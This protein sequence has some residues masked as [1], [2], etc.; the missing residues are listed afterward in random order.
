MVLHGVIFLSPNTLNLETRVPRYL[1][2]SFHRNGNNFHVVCQTLGRRAKHRPLAFWGLAC[3]IWKGH[4]WSLHSSLN[5]SELRETLGSCFD[6]G[7]FRLLQRPVCAFRQWWCWWPLT[8]WDFSWNGAALLTPPTWEECFSA[9]KF[10][11]DEGL[12]TSF[13]VTVFVCCNFLVSLCYLEAYFQCFIFICLSGG[14]LNMARK[15]CGRR[16][17]RLWRCGTNFEVI[18]DLSFRTWLPT[19]KICLVIPSCLKLYKC[20]KNISRNDFACAF[21]AVICRISC[22]QHTSWKQYW[23]RCLCPIHF[24][25]TILQS[26]FESEGNVFV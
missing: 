19:E 6:T 7:L 8:S 24:S 17:S 9:C 1:I 4:H 22:C 12:Q 2:I 18:F 16:E 14:T 13:S 26:L 3:W 20:L 15:R 25:F 23:A 10:T 21:G 11:D 5:K